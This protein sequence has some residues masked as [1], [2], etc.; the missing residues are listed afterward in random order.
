[1]LLGRGLDPIGQ[2]GWGQALADG[3]STAE[4]AAAVFAGPEI[5]QDSVESCYQQFL[6]RVAEPTGLNYWLSELAQGMTEEQVIAGFVGSQEYFNR[7][8]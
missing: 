2:S 8:Q 4:I 1:M 3:V 7:L 5:Q 6:H